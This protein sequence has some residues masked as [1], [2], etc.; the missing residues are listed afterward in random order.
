MNAYNNSDRDY[1]ND[2]INQKM[3]TNTK[4]QKQENYENN[5]PATEVYYDQTENDLNNGPESEYENALG[6]AYQDL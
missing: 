5:Q 4:Q 1:I 2:E 3:Q 6:D